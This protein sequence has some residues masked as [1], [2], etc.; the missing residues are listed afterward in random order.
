MGW[1][2][3]GKMMAGDSSSGV[4]DTWGHTALFV[5]RKSTEYIFSKGFQSLFHNHIAC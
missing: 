2:A 5:T 4:V 1:R 3:E